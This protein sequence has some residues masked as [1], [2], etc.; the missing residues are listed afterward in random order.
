MGV[1]QA[2]PLNP[3]PPLS[4][5]WTSLLGPA[6]PLLSAS[7]ESS[8]ITSMCSRL[9]QAKSM[10]W[11]GSYQDATPLLIVHRVH[12]SPVAHALK[13]H[14]AIVPADVLPLCSH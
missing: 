12:V 10:K 8:S 11:A 2:P 7:E 5:L 14:G 1:S 13:T 4:L 9:I 3:N 6:P